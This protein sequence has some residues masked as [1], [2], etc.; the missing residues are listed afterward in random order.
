MGKPVVTDKDCNPLNGLIGN[1]STGKVYIEVSEMT[2]KTGKTIKSARLE[3][4]QVLN[5]IEYTPVGS[6]IKMTNSSGETV[7]VNKPTTTEDAST[8]DSAEDYI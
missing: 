6:G 1:G 8:N 2:L 4:V 7:V 5:H 3:A